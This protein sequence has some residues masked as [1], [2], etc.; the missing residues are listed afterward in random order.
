MEADEYRHYSLNGVDTSA[1][2]LT[3]DE[4]TG[5]WSTMKQDYPEFY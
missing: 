3:M 1:Y 5:V 4:L 2:G